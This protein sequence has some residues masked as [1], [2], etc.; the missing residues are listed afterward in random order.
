MFEG[1][2]EAAINFYCSI[3][4]NASIDT[5]SYYGPEG[6]GKEGTVIQ[7]V[8]SLYGQQYMAIDSHINHAFTFTPSISIFVA[9]DSEEEIDKFYAAL[10]KEGKEMMPL[11]NYGFSRKF[12]WIIDQF[13]VSWQ[14]NLPS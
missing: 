4:E 13:G 10:S 9:C 11:S 8:F 1:N 3:F 14:L 7:A 5:I 2:A 12:G 6:P